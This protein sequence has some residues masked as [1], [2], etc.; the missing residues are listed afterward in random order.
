MGFFTSHVEVVDL[1][2]GNKVTLRKATFADVAAA[3]SGAL[4]RNGDRLEL[5]WPL[6][7]LE[8][9]KRTVTTWEGLGF[10]GQ[11]PTPE[12][13]AAL[14]SSVGEKLATRAVDLSTLDADAGN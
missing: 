1:G 12:N 13:I 14:P 2:D 11:P 9:V 3:Q 7:R 8:L 6:Y 4:Q 10:D 5:D